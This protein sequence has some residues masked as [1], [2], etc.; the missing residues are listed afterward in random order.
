[1]TRNDAAY[2]EGALNKGLI[3]A[4]CLELG[5][6]YGGETNRALLEAAGLTY[7]GADVMRSAG[8]DFAVDFE[9]APEVVTNAVRDV[10]AFGSVLVLNVLEHTFQPIT[11][12]DNVFKILRPWGTCLI[13]APAV[14]PIH[15]YPR[16]YWRINPDFY[17]EYAKRRGHMIMEEIFSYVG[18]GKIRRDDPD[19]K[20]LPVPFRTK[21]VRRLYSRVIHRVF[22]TFGRG[23]LF[24]SHLAIGVVMRKAGPRPN[25]LREARVRGSKGEFAR[26]PHNSYAQS[27]LA[28]PGGR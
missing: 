1:M 24:P 22:N 4:P 25:P 19:T 11:V 17:E 21:M 2:V 7:F 23:M 3:A 26:E 28:P 6:G 27:P 9:A 10:G 5:V 18:G 20:T 15:S 14:W 13:I 8:V 12:L 16:D